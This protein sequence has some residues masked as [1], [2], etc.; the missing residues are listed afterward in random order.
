MHAIL[1]F[2]FKS[3]LLDRLTDPGRRID[4]AMRGTT[5][6]L[7]SFIKLLLTLPFYFDAMERKRDVFWPV[8]RPWGSARRR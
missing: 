2:S 5:S 7:R 1:R 4:A 8:R 6:V 3:I